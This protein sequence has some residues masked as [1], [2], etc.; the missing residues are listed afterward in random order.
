VA[1]TPSVIAASQEK[2]AAQADVGRI[3]RRCR[4]HTDQL[5]GAIGE[6]RVKA[7]WRAALKL[8]MVQNIANLVSSS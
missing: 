5:G 6:R 4:Q 3:D 2:L 1:I 8:F 7:Y